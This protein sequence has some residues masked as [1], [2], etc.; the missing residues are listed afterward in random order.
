MIVKRKPLNWWER[1][2]FPA[3][4]AGLGITLRHFFRR[5]ITMQYPEERWV[6]PEG[7]RGAPIS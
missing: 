2:Y 7:Y 4:L 6:V 3:I 5:K 1:L